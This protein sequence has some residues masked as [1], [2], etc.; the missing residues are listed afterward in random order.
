M[1]SVLATDIYGATSQHNF[2]ITISNVVNN[3][4]APIISFITSDT[5]IKETD[6]IS[7]E[8]TANDP[9][10]TIPI[11]KWYK[12]TIL[13]CQGTI[14]KIKTDFTS[15]G[16]Q[17]IK[18]IVSDGILE[19]SKQITVTVLDSNRAP[20]SS[21]KDTTLTIRNLNEPIVIS[22]KA[23]DL[24]GDKLIY[25]YDASKFDLSDVDV[26]IEDSNYIY[27]ITLN[28]FVSD[29]LIFTISD[30][31]DAIS[32]KVNIVSET[33][34]SIISKRATLINSFNINS[35]GIIR[36]TVSKTSNVKLIIYYIDGRI[37]YNDNRTMN[38]GVFNTKINVTSGTYIYK[39]MI[40][41]FHK[42]SKIQIIK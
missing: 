7:L 38:S 24:D 6:S 17:I 33:P 28:K 14:Y 29:T 35:K 2:T 20:T 27:I 19:V 8:V 41:K 40:G 22:V 5:T 11:I 34:T 39:F 3:N 12:G 16:T 23:I 10:G 32:F 15:A 1:V 21:Y 26:G 4:V 30:G 31:K 13:V 25:S 18:V 9:D 37:L 36:Y 42:T